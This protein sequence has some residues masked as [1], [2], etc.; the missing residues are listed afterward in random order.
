MITPDE[1]LDLVAQTAAPLAPRACPLHDA[2]GLVLAEDIVADS[3]CPPFRRATMDG[4]AVRISDAGKTV[5]VVGEI[6]AGVYCNTGLT[7]GRCVAI[8]TGAPCPPG[9]EAVVPKELVHQQENRVSL[10]THIAAGQ[11]IAEPGSE[12]RRGQ[13][14][15]TAGT[16]IRPLVAAVLASLGHNIVRII[17]RPALAII[18]TGGELAGE[19]HTLQPGKIR[20][21]NGP[22]IAAMAH[23]LGLSVSRYIHVQDSLT[24]IHEA[25]EQA[26]DA[27]IVVLSGG[28][29]VG[30]YDLVPQALVEIGAESVFHGVKQKPGKPLLFARAGRRLFFGLPGNPLGCHLGFHRY[31]SAA[32]RRM[33]GQEAMPRCYEGQL[34]EPV[35]SKGD[36]THFVPGIAALVNDAEMHS[37]PRLACPTVFSPGATIGLPTVFSRWCLTPLP[38]ASSAD[39]FRTCMANCYIEVPPLNRI[40]QAGET[41][42]FTRLNA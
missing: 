12:C 4:F 42:R 35:E 16:Q 3:D 6:P 20:D 11:H 24:E 9:T 19:G 27:D 32:A 5:P 40:I 21:A 26:S 15:L 33:S 10:P 39:V 13:R 7:D 8:L 31:V 28:V 30:S 38:G 34:T 1:A 37:V 41:C 23:E 22:M 29:S 25:L 18:A 14:V 2:F 17:P 36:R